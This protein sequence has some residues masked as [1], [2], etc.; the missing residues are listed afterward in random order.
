[1]SLSE[2][3]NSILCALVWPWSRT[4][5]YWCVLYPQPA[6]KPLDIQEGGKEDTRTS[7]LPATRNC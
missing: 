2:G 4:A 1:M 6:C 3:M 7:L 5:F